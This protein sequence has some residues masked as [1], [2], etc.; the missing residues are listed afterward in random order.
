MVSAVRP[1]ICL[2]CKLVSRSYKTVL[3][4]SRMLTAVCAEAASVVACDQT[5]V[6]TASH[7]G[8]DL[9]C[10]L[11]AAR[12]YLRTARQHMLA[13][14]SRLGVCKPCTCQLFCARPSVQCRPTL[15]RVVS[16]NAVRILSVRRASGSATC[17]ETAHRRRTC[18][19]AAAKGATG[20]RLVAFGFHL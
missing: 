2:R 15:A 7:H 3:N 17:A 8:C 14:F 13:G 1:T 6:S 19:H 18:I 9:C 10:L 12:T 4:T 11:N 5:V 16:H 20:G